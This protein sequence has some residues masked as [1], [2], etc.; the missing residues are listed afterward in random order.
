MKARHRAWLSTMRSRRVFADE[1]KEKDLFQVAATEMQGYLASAGGRFLQ[2]LDVIS[3]VA[4]RGGDVLEIGANPYFVTAVLLHDFELK[5]TC[6]GRPPVVWPGSAAGT[7]LRQKR[8][9]SVSHATHPIEEVVCNAERDRFPFSDESFDTV[10]AA[11]I[12][13]H[14][15]YSP[16]HFLYEIQRVLRPGGRLILTTPNAVQLRYLVRWFQGRSN[17]DQYSGYGVYGRHQREYTPREVVKLL[18]ALNFSV[19]EAIT[20]YAP[21]VDSPVAGALASA[22][23]WLA[24]GRQPEM[25]FVARRTG[26]PRVSYPPFLYRSV[27]PEPDDAPSM[28]AFNQRDGT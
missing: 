19:D 23:H 3:R 16:T 10:I 4:G 24:P 2:T 22:L 14:L 5:V 26:Q 1:A 18:T 25:T 15:I 20:Y 7:G 12:L 8:F 13:E 28:Y 27:Y 17:W 9:L 11:E 6:M 21:R